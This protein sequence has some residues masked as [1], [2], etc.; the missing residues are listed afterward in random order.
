MLP[1]LFD[2]AASS[3]SNLSILCDEINSTL[4]GKPW[5]KQALSTMTKLDSTLRESMRINSFVT[6]ALQ[7]Q[8][9]HPD[10]VTTP[11]GIHLPCGTAVASPGHPVH[12]DPDIYGPDAREFKPFRFAEQ[13]SSNE[14]DD[15]KEYLKKAKMSFPTTSSSYLAFG[16]G[17]L[18]CP[19]RFFASNELK[20][21]V[22][23][24]ALNYEI[25]HLDTRPPDQWFGL[26]RT[27]DMKAKIRVRRRKG[28]V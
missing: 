3:P 28:T 7:R 1:A 25:E 27:P 6:V 21:M 18:A 14:G 13:R 26:I 11:Q 19:G 2:L 23:W 15:T 16:H 9:V 24:I 5:S 17:R 20:L 4:N 10:G 22:A 8:V 12:Q